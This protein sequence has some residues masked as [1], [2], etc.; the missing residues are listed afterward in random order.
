VS[1]SE[2]EVHWRAFLKSL[3]RLVSA[4]EMEISEDWIA[5]K[6]RQFKQKERFYGK[7]TG[8]LLSKFVSLLLIGHI[9]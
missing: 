8:N 6:K 7:K 5:G 2:A 1:L 3:L 9:R 4:V